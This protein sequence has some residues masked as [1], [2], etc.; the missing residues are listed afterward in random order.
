MLQ[1][2]ASHT[3]NPS[4][5]NYDRNMFIIQ[6]TAKPTIVKVGWCKPNPFGWH[7]DTQHINIKHN[8]T[9]HHN[10]KERDIQHKRH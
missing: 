10:N 8:G 5:V 3:D 9:H 6:A 7:N 2:G 4:S 1:F